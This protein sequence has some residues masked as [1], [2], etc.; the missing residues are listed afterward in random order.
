MR[1]ANPTNNAVTIY[2]DESCHLEHDNQ[3]V[4]LLGCIWIPQQKIV[5][6]VEE[7]RELKRAHKSSG[8][9]KW[10]KVSNSRL[11][12]FLNLVDW[13]FASPHLHFRCLVVPD[14]SALNH[15]AFNQGSHDV[16][17]YKMY[18]SLLNKILDPGVCHDIYI[19]I[20]DTRSKFKIQKLHEILCNDRYDFTQQMIRK[21]QH[22]RSHEVELLQVADFLLGAVSYRH[23]QLTTSRAKLAIVERIEKHHGRGLVWTTPLSETKFNIFV[24]SPRVISS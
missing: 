13:F 8:E 17:Y 16:F 6:A 3:K 2:C 18:F 11:P 24:W 15:D 21:I 23:R 19:D 20:K 9:L 4:M 7:F 14:K 10:V 12:F 1:M 22:V 5:E